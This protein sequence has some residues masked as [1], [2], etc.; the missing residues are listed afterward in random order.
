MHFL[1]ILK[2]HKNK[3]EH[4]KSLITKQ[5]IEDIRPKVLE[6]RAKILKRY[7][8]RNEYEKV[9]FSNK[10]EN[11][12]NE[13]YRT[14]TKYEEVKNVPNKTVSI[15]LNGISD[16]IKKCNERILNV[17]LKCMSAFEK[18]NRLINYNVQI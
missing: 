1:N 11:I 2:V 7:N 15:L 12:S 17:N 8:L 14:E 18:A 4:V 16:N 10:D 5:Y 9:N 13:F 3:S 6:I